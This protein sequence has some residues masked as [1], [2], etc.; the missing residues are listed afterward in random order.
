L[1]ALTSYLYS[2][3]VCRLVFWGV[4]T[5]NMPCLLSDSE[6]ATVGHRPRQQK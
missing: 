3:S 2:Y 6:K 4:N 5:R 1:P